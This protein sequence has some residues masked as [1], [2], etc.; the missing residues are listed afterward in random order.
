[1]AGPNWTLWGAVAGLFLLPAAVIGFQY[2]KFQYGLDQSSATVSAKDLEDGKIPTA[3]NLTITDALVDEEHSVQWVLLE[4]GSERERYYIHPVRAL[5]GKKT[6]KKKGSSGSSVKIIVTS[7]S[8][9]IDEGELK[10]ILRNLG[11]DGVGKAIV[12]KFGEQGVS[13]DE[14]AILVEIGA[15][16]Q[17]ELL[18]VLFI[19]GCTL[20][21]PISVI[22]FVVA[23]SRKEK[24]DQKRGVKLEAIRANPPPDLKQLEEALRA[25]LAPYAPRSDDS[26]YV[27]SFTAVGPFKVTLHVDDQDHDAPPQIF[28][29]V[30][31]I[32]ECYRKHGAKVESVHY[33]CERN[34][35]DS[36]WRFRGTAS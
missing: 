28:S 32:H 13:V 35:E 24:S 15:T 4:N 19:A 3:H 20:V 8:A 14:K 1:M 29:L 34:D 30:Q 33:F 31:Q 6:K 7:E 23:T 21:A 26:F 36:P 27:Y 17:G 5:G 12:D 22:G 18:S 16:T 10:G 25:A 11:G 2:K 9:S